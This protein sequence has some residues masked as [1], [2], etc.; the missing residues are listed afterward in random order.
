[1][2]QLKEQKDQGIPLGDRLLIPSSMLRMGE[3]VFLDDIT[4]DQIEKGL[5][6]K[7]VPVESGG[8]AFLDAILNADYRMNRNNE[9]IGYI[10]AYED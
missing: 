9:N 5:A 7:L 2:K 8:R 6:I 3:N 4:G 1:M 10:K